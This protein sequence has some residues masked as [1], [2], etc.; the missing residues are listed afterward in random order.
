NQIHSEEENVQMAFEGLWEFLDSKKKSELQK[1][2]K[3]KEDVM[4]SLAESQNELEKQREAVRDLIS[5]MQH[6]LHFP[7]I[8]MLQGVN[9]VLTRIQTLRVKLPK[10]IP[11]K[12]RSI[13]RAPDVKGML[14]VY[15]GLMDAQRYWVH[16]TLRQVHNKNVDINME[17]RQ[18]QC[19][20][21]CR[22]NLQDY[23]TYDLGVLGIPAMQSGKHY[24]EVDVSR[25]DAWLLGLNDGRCAQPQLHSKN[26]KGIMHSSHDEQHV[27]FQPKY[28]Y[29]VIVNDSDESSTC[30][31]T[32][33]CV[34]KCKLQ[35]ISRNLQYAQEPADPT[36]AMCNLS[37]YNPTSF[38]LVGI[39]GLEKFHIWI[40][41][42]F[43]VIYVVAI[44][45][46]HILLYLTEEE[47]SIHEAMFI[48]LSMLARHISSCLLPQ[49]A[50]CLVMS[51]V[52][53]QG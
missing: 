52:V 3:E 47:H 5:D 14:Q 23:E 27:N 32:L 45:G 22:R 34:V 13:F 39:P 29:W 30:K 15:Q 2:M 37:C 53:P 4:N 25:S 21:S 35:N 28:G 41:I 40:R 7:T 49:Y 24:W 16:V 44:V 17:K 20:Y 1:L 26:Q 38:I 51:S 18:I 19:Q 12:Q 11:R 46:N 10:I 33:C 6:H 8:E 31:L 36:E 48:F 43:C 42:P 50:N 9:S